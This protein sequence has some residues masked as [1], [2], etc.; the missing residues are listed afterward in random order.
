MV[1]GIIGAGF[2]G[3]SSAKVLTELGHHVTVYDKT[4]DVGGVWSSTRRYP[5]LTTQNNKGTYALSGLPMPSSYPEWPTGEQVQRYLETYVDTFALRPML[6]LGTE[7]TRAEPVA[8]GGWDVTTPTDTVHYD[9]LV[10]AN[11]IFSTPFVPEF[12]GA[13][14]LRAAGG[15]IIPASE[16]L[17]IE[18]V[19][20]KNVVVVGYGKSACDIAV[21]IAPAAASTTVVA[22]ELLWKMPRKIKNVVNYKYL[23]LTRLGEAL[24]RYR[25]VTGVEKAMHA[26]NSALANGLLGSVEKVTTGQL[27]LAEVNLVPKG[28]FSDIARSTVSLASN[29]FFEAVKAGGIRVERDTVITRLEVEEGSST[30]VLS[31]GSTVLADVVVAATGW[32]QDQPF[33]PREVV[34]RLTDDNG[35]FLL[36]RQI[37]PIG[38]P[39][40][41]FAGYN[42]SF[43]SPLS[44]EMSAVWIGS[45]LA[46]GHTVPSEAEQRAQVDARLAWM[47]E[48]TQGKHAKGTN[49]IP[50]SMKNI[51][52]VL[53]DLDLNVG[54]GTRAGQWLMPVNPGAYAGV[55][56][57]LVRRLAQTSA[58]T[59]APATV[60][61]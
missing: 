58:K 42:S 8:S 35:D 30:A 2:A 14:E 12:D 39:D 54:S 50:F 31:N 48:R 18:Q 1:I 36:Y 61:G 22:R 5:G 26:N 19:R 41:T 55:T 21:A 34:D 37:L 24:F 3:L 11:G 29:G 40:L 45:Y 49:I 46:G 25:T 32:I 17:D 20:G 23:M 52:E 10:L 27:G 7:V 47:R 57:K 38:V 4:P 9:H 6:R 43:F 16:L 33:L 28:R 44:A 15:V 60:G 13:A 51:D 53:N 59:S 56:P